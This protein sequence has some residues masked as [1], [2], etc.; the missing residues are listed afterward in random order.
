MK[1][2]V[3]DD[4]EKPPEIIDPGMVGDVQSVNPEIIHTLTEKGF[5]PI[6]AP[7]GV[8]KRGNLQ[9]QRGCGGIPDCGVFGSGALDPAHGCGRSPGCGQSTDIFYQ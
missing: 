8:E 9:H 3:Q 5:I 7:V 4:Q 6:I 1:I 2:Y